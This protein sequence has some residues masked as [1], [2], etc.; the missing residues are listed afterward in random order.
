MRFCADGLPYFTHSRLA[1]IDTAILAVSV[2][3]VI[4]QASG[5]AQRYTTMNALRVAR[6][7]RV[8]RLVR[9][10]AGW[11]GVF[12]RIAQSMAPA[13]NAL[14]LL[15]VFMVTFALVGMQ[16]RGHFTSSVHSQC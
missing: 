16:A 7:L 12:D 10:S 15:V 4:A 1:K 3:D 5:L 13:L 6:A 11:L 9:L 14:A 2:L 8:M